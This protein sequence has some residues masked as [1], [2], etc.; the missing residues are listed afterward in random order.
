MP[1]DPGGLLQRSEGRTLFGSDPYRYEAGRPDYPDRVYEVL[2]DRC[3]LRTAVRILEIGPGTGLVTRHL[4]A[5]GASVT[6]VEPDA[7]L[8]RYLAG[9]HPDVEVVAE[10]LEEAV[11]PEAT[12]DLSVA[13]TSLH[14]VDQQIGLTKMGRSVRPGGWV[15]VWWTLFR[16]PGHP[17]PFAEAIEEILGPSTRG[18][19][20]E[21]GRPPFQLDEEHRLRDL[22]RWAGLGQLGSERFRSPCLF[23]ARGARALYASMA[24][25][26]RRPAAEQE[27]L[28]DAIEELVVHRFGGTVERQFVTAIYTGRRP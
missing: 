3:G 9:T 20:D 22:D 12:F 23:S 13:A 4:L 18:A 16:D 24:T 6:A 15:A 28:L 14:W 10:P 21:P 5:T 1:T 26:L 8:A 7:G 17:D 11:L 27:R 25:V 19:F 2:A